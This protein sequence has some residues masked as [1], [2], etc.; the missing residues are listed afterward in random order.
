MRHLYGIIVMANKPLI[1]VMAFKK[2]LE[3]SILSALPDL[4]SHD[5]YPACCIHVKMHIIHHSQK[6]LANSEH[7]AYLLGTGPSPDV[8]C[9][10]STRPLAGKSIPQTNIRLQKNM[11]TYKGRT[12]SNQWLRNLKMDLRKGVYGILY[13]PLEYHHSQV[14]RL[15]INLW[16]CILSARNLSTHPLIHWSAFSFAPFRWSVGSYSGEPRCYPLIEMVQ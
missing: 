7:T 4:Q 15:H 8:T 13:T 16:G 2:A 9:I 3:G 14:P 10:L 11:T 5:I 6:P 1:I 12:I